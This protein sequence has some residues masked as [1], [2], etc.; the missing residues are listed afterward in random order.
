[1]GREKKAACSGLEALA[2]V[3]DG[4][5]VP[6]PSQKTLEQ[7]MCF[8]AAVWNG[9]VIYAQLGEWEPIRDVMRRIDALREPERTRMSELFLAAVE[10]WLRSFRNAGWLYRHVHVVVG[11]GGEL[12]VRA[13]C[14]PLGRWLNDGMTLRVGLPD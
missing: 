14:I 2:Q 11:E 4:A 7:W 5:V 12:R 9:M 8:L 13:E 3:L 10:R 6:R 1:M